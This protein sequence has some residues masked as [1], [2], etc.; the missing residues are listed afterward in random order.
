MTYKFNPLIGKST[1]YN[2]IKGKI[3]A[4]GGEVPLKDLLDYLGKQGYF[5]EALQP[6]LKDLGIDVI[7]G[8]ARLR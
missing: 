2:L 8:K 3:E 7:D 5:K 1:I 4:E 6:R